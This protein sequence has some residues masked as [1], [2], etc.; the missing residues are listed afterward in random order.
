MDDH[1]GRKKKKKSAKKTKTPKCQ[2]PAK[3]SMNLYLHLPSI[4]LD[5]PPFEGVAEEVLGEAAWAG[6]NSGRDTPLT[7]TEIG[8]LLTSAMSKNKTSWVLNNLA[9]LFWR[10]EGDA[11]E[12]TRCLLGALSTSPY[13]MKDV[14][15]IQ[16]ANVLYLA[17]AYD[18]AIILVKAAL[19]ISSNT[20]AANYL[21][22]S[23]LLVR[24]CMLV[25]LRK[26]H[27]MSLTNSV[28]LLFSVGILSS[29]GPGRR[30]RR[31]KGLCPCD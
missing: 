4:S 12:A 23:I 9:A 5:T 28:S 16:L 25:C 30:F 3:F 7:H 24:Y 8:T 2:T 14:A 15:L 18:D 11:H 19:A 29:S 26:L 22:G 20:Y 27:V 31:T 13:E 1:I 21:H 17:K 6:I 10:I